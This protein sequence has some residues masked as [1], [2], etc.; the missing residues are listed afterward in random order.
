MPQNASWENMSNLHKF[1][2]GAECPEYDLFH[3]LISA[4][5]AILY[6]LM[7]FKVNF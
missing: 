5:Q 7:T 3:R 6:I 1:N 2:M 4:K